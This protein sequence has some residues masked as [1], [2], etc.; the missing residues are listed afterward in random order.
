[1]DDILSPCY[2]TQGCTEKGKDANGELKNR[3]HQP[4]ERDDADT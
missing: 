3:L 2:R 4:K 1:M